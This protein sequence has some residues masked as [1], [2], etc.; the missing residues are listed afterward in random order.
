MAIHILLTAVLTI[1]GAAPVTA[2]DTTPPSVPGTPVATQVTETS[3]LLTWR[4]STD[5]TGVS[6]Y[7]IWF[8]R[9]DDTGFHNNSAVPSYRFTGLT[10]DSTYTWMVRASDGRNQSGF[11]AP[12]TFRTDPAPQ[13]SEPPTA[14][15]VPVVTDFTASSFDLTWAP[16]TDN[17]SAPT[18][19]VHARPEAVGQATVVG[20]GDEPAARVRNLIPDLSYDLY[21]VARDVSGNV[22]APSP[23]VRQ[24]LGSDPTA[25]CR[26]SFQPGAA[27]Q[28][29]TLWI[30]NTGQVALQAWSSRFHFTGGQRLWDVAGYGWA[31][32][33]R[34]VVLWW[35]GWS[36][37]FS[38]GE[39][40]PVRL[41]LAAGPLD[42]APTYVSLNGVACTVVT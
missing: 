15:G 3:A 18:Y 16:S 34:D 14:P 32:Y 5:D 40:L 21:V 28:P 22:S 6:Q 41:H 30:T 27:G 38:V 24:R 8:Q 9:P 1:A 17:A 39:T 2:A 26:V 19:L 20:G 10:P 33:D 23:S 13:E 29:P 7:E 25:D 36:D 4:P 42:A 12:V 37:Q 11:S 35:S 31:Q